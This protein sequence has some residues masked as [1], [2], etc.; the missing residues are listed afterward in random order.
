MLGVGA[1]VCGAV[2][3]QPEPGFEDAVIA[4]CAGRTGVNAIAI[5]DCSAL[6]TGGPRLYT[7]QL[8]LRYPAQGAK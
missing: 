6:A 7:P 8:L 5:R 2:C 1:L 4:V 3:S